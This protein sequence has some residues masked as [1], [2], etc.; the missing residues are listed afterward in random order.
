MATEK[1]N[2]FVIAETLERLQA[3]RRPFPQD[4]Q[5]AIRLIEDLTREADSL[6][7]EVTRLTSAL[8][9]RDAEIDA[10]KAPREITPVLPE[11]EPAPGPRRRRAAAQD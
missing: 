1:V 11:P 4:N 7:G 5:D 8:A 3:R 6:R 2:R 10:L 9:A